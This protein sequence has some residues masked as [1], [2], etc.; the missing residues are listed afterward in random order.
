MDLEFVYRHYTCFI[1]NSNL[2]VQCHRKGGDLNISHNNKH[3][4]DEQIYTL[5]STKS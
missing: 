5:N 4:I 3:K 1:Q 2:E